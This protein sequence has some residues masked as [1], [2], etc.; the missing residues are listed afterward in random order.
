MKNNLTSRPPNDRL[1]LAAMLLTGTTVFCLLAVLLVTGLRQLRPDAM[2][3]AACR[4]FVEQYSVHTIALMPPGKYLRHSDGRR[5]DVDLR[6][7]PRLPMDN[8]DAGLVF[9]LQPTRFYSSPRVP[10]EGP[11]GLNEGR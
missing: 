6:Y 11:A 1:T 2:A 5:P 4:Q 8:P 9:L 10:A 7:D 3:A